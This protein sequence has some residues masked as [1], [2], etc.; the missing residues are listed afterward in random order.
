MQTALLFWDN[1]AINRIASETLKIKNPT[2]ENTNALLSTVMAASTS[3]LRFPGYMNND[4]AGLISSLVPIP[5]CHFITPGYTPFF[6]SNLRRSTVSDVMRRL[7]SPKT[8]LVS[9]VPSK[10]NCY[11][12]LLNILS[13][14]IVPSDISASLVRIRERR[15]AT[16]V[17]WAPASLQVSVVRSSP[18]VPSHVTGC[19][20]ANS[21]SIGALLLRTC[22]QF[23]RLRK[24]NAFTD[25]YRREEMFNDGLEEFDESRKVVGELIS[26]YSKMETP[27]YN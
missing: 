7:L 15:L 4:M 1:A 16:F 6:T 10:R 26:E 3:T 18:Y 12:S 25:I 9:V 27:D 23:D 11:V 2:F 14:D 22:D 19:M 5:R 20:L 8:R 24:R 21:T 13:G 17:P